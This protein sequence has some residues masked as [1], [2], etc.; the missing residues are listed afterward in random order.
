MGGFLRIRRPRRWRRQAQFG[1]SPLATHSMSA[2]SQG[3]SVLFSARVSSENKT[4]SYPSSF[5]QAESS[6]HMIMLGVR[7]HFNAW[8]AGLSWLFFVAKKGEALVH[9]VRW[10]LFLKRL[11]LLSMFSQP[12]ILFLIDYI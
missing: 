8:A 12:P 9:G 11:L 5:F 6:S 3:S 7:Q 1:V 2:L 10:R 4:L